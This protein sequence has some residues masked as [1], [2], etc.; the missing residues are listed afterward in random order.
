MK[1]ADYDKG[2][3]SCSLR[4]SFAFIYKV[5]IRH[6]I[7]PA[8]VKGMKKLRRSVFSWPSSIARHQMQLKITRQTFWLGS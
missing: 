7:I 4:K 3:W 2:I 5:K 8:A 1:A 6:L